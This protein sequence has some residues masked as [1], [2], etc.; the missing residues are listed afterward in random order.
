[1]HKWKSDAE[2]NDLATSI[3]EAWRKRALEGGI[4]ELPWTL[5]HLKDR[6]A[7]IRGIIDARA[8]DPE[9]RQAPGGKTGMLTVTYKLRAMGD[10]QGQE[11]VREFAFDAALNEAM[12]AIEIQVMTHLGQWQQKVELSADESLTGVLKQLHE[13][14]QRVAEDRARTAAATQPG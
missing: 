11:T 2:F 1:L 3:R 8:K 7:R 13:G 6:H 10:K 14:R 12:S 4:C 9:H 5:R